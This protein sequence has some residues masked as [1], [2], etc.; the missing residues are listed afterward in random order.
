MGRRQQD[1]AGNLPI[2]WYN[3]KKHNTMFQR[4]N[5]MFW[6]ARQQPW[7][8]FT[9]PSQFFILQLPSISQPLSI[10]FAIYLLAGQY[11]NIGQWCSIVVSFQYPIAPVMGRPRS[12]ISLFNTIYPHESN[13]KTHENPK[14]CILVI[15][16]GIGTGVKSTYLSFH[17]SISHPSILSIL[18]TV[19]YIY[20][21]LSYLYVSIYIYLHLCLY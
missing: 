17:P 20:L 11:A 10:Y 9:L 15:L 14:L 19:Y 12:M 5:A 2:Q 1:L 16:F 6:R 8:K 4:N 3:V 7:D 13:M 21:N 18:S